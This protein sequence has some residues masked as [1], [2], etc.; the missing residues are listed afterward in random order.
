MRLASRLH[1]LAFLTFKK[2]DLTVSPKLSPVSWTQWFSLV[3]LLSRWDHTAHATEPSFLSLHYAAILKHLHPPE[4]SPVLLAL[5]SQSPSPCPTLLFYLQ[6]QFM[7]KSSGTLV[8]KV[9]R[10]P[11]TCVARELDRNAEWPTHCRPADP[12]IIC[13]WIRSPWG[14]L[15]INIWESNLE[16]KGTEGVTERMHQVK[17]FF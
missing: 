17:E 6:I 13:I 11:T 4:D 16:L 3:S 14:L 15:N 8:V 2:Q 5:P 7:V 9:P 10:S 1:W 12:C